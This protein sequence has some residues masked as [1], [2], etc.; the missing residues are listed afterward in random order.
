MRRVATAD[1]GS[2]RRGD[3]HIDLAGRSNHLGSSGQVGGPTERRVVPY[4]HL[5]S[6]G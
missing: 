3:G 4:V 2:T 6:A 1:E 5:V